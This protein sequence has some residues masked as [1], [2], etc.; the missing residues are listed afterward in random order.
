VIW[1]KGDPW[2]PMERG[3]ALHHAIGH[4]GWSSLPQVGHL[5]QL[6]APE[7]VLNA[8]LPLLSHDLKR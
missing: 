7:A 8:L 1:G 6:E 4:A 3:R 2:I 5:P